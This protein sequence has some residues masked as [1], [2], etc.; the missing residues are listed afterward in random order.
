MGAL[1]I[2]LVSIGG[3][4]GLVAATSKLAHKE[5][6]RYFSAIGLCIAILGFGLGV[7]LALARQDASAQSAL[8]AAS[9]AE[10]Q[11]ALLHDQTLR[12]ESQSIK[13]QELLSEIRRAQLR[14]DSFGIYARLRIPFDLDQQFNEYYD[15]LFARIADLTESR[16][17]EVERSGHLIP[18]RAK[19]GGPVT[20]A[21]VN[22]DGPFGPH[23]LGFPYVDLLV[24]SVCIRIDIYPAD[25]PVITPQKE[26]HFTPTVAR[27]IPSLRTGHDLHVSTDGLADG[28]RF[29]SIFCGSKGSGQDWVE[30]SEAMSSIP[31]LAGAQIAFHVYMLNWE[32]LM[33][34]TP[35]DRPDDRR[36]LSIM[37]GVTFSEPTLS[38]GGLD[39]PMHR[40][41]CV[42]ARQAPQGEYVVVYQ[43]PPD[44]AALMELG[45][46]P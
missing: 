46:R 18:Y 8:A 5:H 38:F 25:G 4:G 23:S 42:A 6:E 21:T 12:L 43:M 27:A 40:A 19:R 2:I 37:D 32:E 28:V 7:A 22:I 13:Q 16:L 15:A 30:R 20:A 36:F 11:L 44:E 39:L 35:V 41:Q 33:R 10:Q 24:R 17:G 31:D 26:W 3:I 34:A 14:F 9:Q 29:G 1:E 45:G